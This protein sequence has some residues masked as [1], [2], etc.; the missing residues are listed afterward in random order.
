MARIW[1]CCGCGV[2]WQLWLQFDPLPGNFICLGCDPKKTKKK[3][4]KKKKTGSK[5][6]NNAFVL[7]IQMRWGGGFDLKIEKEI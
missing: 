2:G 7:D 6:R 5:D 1:R 4:K 3:K